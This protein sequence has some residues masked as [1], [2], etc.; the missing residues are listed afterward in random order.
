MQRVESIGVL[1]HAPAR[2]G[3]LAPAAPE[4]DR[5]VRPIDESP[6]HC[7]VAVGGIE[8]S[9]LEPQHPDTKLLV[10]GTHKGI[11]LLTRL[12]AAER[13]FVERRI[14]LQQPKEHLDPRPV[15]GHLPERL[16]LRPHSRRHRVHR[17][18]RGPIQGFAII[19]RAEAA[20]A[21]TWLTHPSAV[22]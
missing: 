21:D 2:L 9:L 10:E 13:P 3:Y 18:H 4:G 16:P 8:D 5:L 1:L 15:N 20:A 12:V 7:R 22:K 19:T 17:P 14:R 6:A 11:V